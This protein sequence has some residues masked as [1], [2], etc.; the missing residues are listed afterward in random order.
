MYHS[1]VHSMEL[2]H[3]KQQSHASCLASTMNHGISQRW[4]LWV[5][6]RKKRLNWIKNLTTFS[7]PG[8]SGMIKTISGHWVMEWNSGASSITQPSSPITQMRKVKAKGRAAV[9][10]QV[11]TQS[12]FHDNTNLISQY[13]CLI[14]LLFH[15]NSPSTSLT[16]EMIFYYKENKHGFS[17]IVALI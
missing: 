8:Q 5:W 14:I 16:D 4:C 12:S 7:R 17:L 2:M 1:C 10:I 15:T 3:F 9:R 11:S 13:Q 6:N